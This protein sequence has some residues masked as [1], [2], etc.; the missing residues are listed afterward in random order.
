MEGSAVVAHSEGMYELCLYQ[1]GG[2]DRDYNVGTRSSCVGGI[3]NN[4]TLTAATI[5]GADLTASSSNSLVGKALVLE[6]R[7]IALMIDLDESVTPSATVEVKLQTSAGVDIDM[8]TSLT[9]SSK[10]VQVLSWTSTP[11]G[12]YKLV[13]T[14]NT[15]SQGMIIGEYTGGDTYWK[16]YMLTTHVDAQTGSIFDDFPALG[17]NYTNYVAEGWSFPSSGS[18]VSLPE[19]DVPASVVEIAAVGA[20][21][22]KNPTSSPQNAG[23]KDS[24]TKIMCSFD[25]KW[26]S[27]RMVFG[28]AL[29]SY[30]S[31]ANNFRFQTDIS[32][33]QCTQMGI[34]SCDHSFHFHDYGDVA[35]GNGG[36]EVSPSTLGNY[37]SSIDLGTLTLSGTSSVVTTNTHISASAATF[38]SLIGV[39]LTVHDGPTTADQTVAWGVCGVAPADACMRYG[40]ADVEYEA[41]VGDDDHASRSASVASWLLVLVA[42]LPLCNIL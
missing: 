10:A 9:Y 23:G 4:L 26:G 20:I 19:Y 22:L 38:E 8:T 31:T 11:T 17:E 32:G 15:G 21:G 34:T 16:T 7:S 12:T 40:C 42:L 14:S 3:D 37:I 13:V 1:Y 41:P 6:K 29:L 39:S 36:A 5:S 25:D 28:S 33:L 24:T 27:S 18:Y 35:S 2:Y 30:N